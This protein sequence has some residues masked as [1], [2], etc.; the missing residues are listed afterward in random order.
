MDIVRYSV[1]LKKEWDNF[2]EGAKNPLFMFKRDYMEYHSDRFNDNSLMFYNDG[3]LIALF[4][5]S[6]DSNILSS[7]AG[8][9]YGGFISEVSMKQHKME[10]CFD[11]LINYCSNSNINKIVYKT[12]PYIHYKQPSQEDRYSL[13]QRGAKLVCVYPSSCLD[14]KNPLKMAKG[15]K[16]QISRARR[17]GVLIEECNDLKDYEEFIELE[18]GVLKEHHNSKAVHS[19]KEL[20]YLH[21][22]FPENIHLYVGKLNGTIISGA[23][24]YEYEDVVHTQYLAANEKSREIGALDLVIANIIEKYKDSK[25]W[26]DFG[27]SSEPYDNSLNL[28]LIAQKEGFGARTVCNE[29]WEIEV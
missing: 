21:D 12:I 16:A 20:K 1:E 14:L 18:N 17:D 28:G 8:L 27:K 10:E 13:F 29:I 11:L 9:T 15:R 19:G 23:V 5:A 24:I 22:R 2:V 25:D 6:V 3:E 26:L 7:H 4:P